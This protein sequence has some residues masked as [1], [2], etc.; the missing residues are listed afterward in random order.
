MNYGHVGRPTNEEVAARKRKQILKIAIPV[1]AIVAIIGIIASNNGLNGLMG[2]GTC[3]LTCEDGWTLDG[4]VCYQENVATSEINAYLVGDVVSENGDLTPDGKVTLQDWKVIKNAIDN[5]ETLTEEQKLVYDLNG[6]G[7]VN[8][9]D[10][11]SYSTSIS[12]EYNYSPKYVCPKQIV[13]EKM[14]NGTTNVAAT[15]TITTVDYTLNGTKCSV[16]TKIRIE[17]KAAC[18]Q[19][20][21]TETKPEVTPTPQP[22]QEQPEEIQQPAT[23]SETGLESCTYDKNQNTYICNNAQPINSNVTDVTDVDD[24]YDDDDV[25]PIDQDMEYDEEAGDAVLNKTSNYLKYAANSSNEWKIS[26]SSIDSETN[27]N[28]TLNFKYELFKDNKCSQTLGESSI[29]DNNEKS[30]LYGLI[31]NVYRDKNSSSVPNKKSLKIGP[32]IFK[33]NT[34]VANAVNKNGSV[35]IY[36]KNI[37]LNNGYNIQNNCQSVTIKK[38]QTS[39]PNVTFKVKASKYSTLKIDF[40]DLKSVISNKGNISYTVNKKEYSKIPSGYSLILQTGK[41]KNSA[42]SQLLSGIKYKKSKKGSEKTYKL[43]GFNLIKDNSYLCYKTAK[44]NNKEVVWQ[45]NCSHGRVLFLAK[46]GN[47]MQK[48]Q[49]ADYLNNG[50]NYILKAHWKTNNII[51][52]LKNAATKK[53]YQRHAKLQLYTTSESCLKKN[54]ANKFG[55]LKIQSSM[56]KKNDG[57]IK[58]SNNLTIGKTYYL[59]VDISN[60]YNDKKSPQCIAI[61][62]TTKNKNVL[63][64]PKTFD[65]NYADGSGGK[66]TM[67]PTKNKKTDQAITLKKNTYTKKGYKFDHWVASRKVTVNGKKVTQYKGFASTKAKNAKRYSWTTLDNCK[68]YGYKEYADKDKMNINTPEGNITMHAKWKKKESK[69]K[70]KTNKPSSGNN[71]GSSSSANNNKNVTNNNVTNNNVINNNP[72]KTSKDVKYEYKCTGKDWYKISEKQ[73]GKRTTPTPEKCP[74]G[75]DPKGGK[76]VDIVKAEIK[77]VCPNAD[78]KVYKNSRCYFDKIKNHKCP[79]GTKEEQKGKCFT[80]QRPSKRATCP[81]DD[82]NPIKNNKCQKI[83]PMITEYTCKKGDGTLV[84]GGSSAYCWKTKA[85]KKVVKK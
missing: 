42:L 57:V 20:V 49:L 46:N 66:D 70:K 85:A 3:Q 26:V 22:E 8:E 32:T 29:T 28:S 60:F 33:D 54:A 76:C 19:E 77:Y 64:V 2:N 44:H 34:Y 14:S 35:N 41:P 52:K 67:T 43:A 6:D 1:I 61:K 37:V 84:G 53:A 56:N 78:F 18:K 47:T 50:G 79:S 65:V 82:Y 45:K 69:Q 48:I 5:N 40:G 73:C 30:G 71:N 31:I 63:L 80:N 7:N 21:K 59:R 11:S 62:A 75:F 10:V 36:V 55:E 9:S 72:K 58:F 39:I 25:N 68:K 24:D 23:A 83:V 38:G 27:L 51:V 74:K 13:D 16:N 81:W 12:G 4:T 15:K 17:K